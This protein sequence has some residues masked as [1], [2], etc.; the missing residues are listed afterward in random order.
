M[1]RHWLIA[2]CWVGLL[3]LASTVLLFGQLM[4]AGAVVLTPFAFIGYLIGPARSPHFGNLAWYVLLWIVVMLGAALL[5]RLAFKACEAIYGRGGQRPPAPAGRKKAVPRPRGP[6]LPPMSSA[7]RRSS[8]A[9]GALA[10]FLIGWVVP[11]T[12]L[13]E[14]SARI[15]RV[16]SKPLPSTP[17]EVS[18]FDQRWLP[19]A[20]AGDAYAQ[21]VVGQARLH[22]LLGQTRDI[23]EG[24]AWLRK[25]AAQGD[26]DARLSL[27][28][29]A[30]AGNLGT[31]RQFD[32]ESGLVQLTGSLDGWRL[33]ALELLLANN[34]PTA[35]GDGALDLVFERQERAIRWFERAARHGSRYG[36]FMLARA[37]EQ[38]R[39]RAKQ[40]SPDVDA[41]L[42]WYAAAGADSEVERLRKGTSLAVPEA[43]DLPLLEA[44]PASARDLERLRRRAALLGATAVYND[45]QYPLWYDALAHAVVAAEAAGDYPA[46]AALARRDREGAIA[47]MF[48]RAAKAAR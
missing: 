23:G 11:A 13:Y 37:L 6:V 33:A 46:A 21:F 40:P 19:D 27:L 34:Y 8:L 48:E 25:G 32:V 1:T 10:A 28:V 38:R 39:D 17:A 20:K 41:A 45:R 43:G 30:N 15:D 4:V 44:F 35:V 26:P 9:A 18:E 3:G 12:L 22:G 29:E 14:R 24:V 5:A 42:R 36:A 47:A 2:A 31:A 16:A 7:E